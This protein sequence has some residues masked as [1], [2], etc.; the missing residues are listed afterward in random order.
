MVRA[1]F[2][3]SDTIAC[4]LLRGDAV[5]LHTNMDPKQR[6]I[7][8]VKSGVM[9]SDFYSADVMV[10]QRQHSGQVFAECQRANK[11]GITTVYDIDDDFLN[12]PREFIKPY[13][14]YS[15]PGT[16]ASIL[17]FLGEVDEVWV[18]TPE[19]QAAVDKYTGGATPSRIVQNY[20][21]PA[22]WNLA[23][24]LHETNDSDLVTVGWMASGSH[25][26][27][28][29]LV[30][31]ALLQLLAEHPNVRL[32]FIG[33]VGFSEIPGLEAFK[34][35]VRVDPW[36]DLAQLPFAMSGWDIGLC[37]LQDNKFN[38]CKS[39]IKYMQYGS[40]GCVPV[41]SPLRLYREVAKDKGVYAEGNWYE[42]LKKLVVEKDYRRD[43]ALAIRADVL[44]NWNMK[45]G[46]EE[47]ISAY[48][49]VRKK[50]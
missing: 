40:F 15:N 13:Q 17:A 28:A 36:V 47:W 6:V 41:M 26:I 12:T 42:V 2:Y 23:Y 25:S 31:P 34:D 18:T 14:F 29:P 35:R 24:A 9:S 21:D 7:I 44:E 30:G 10:F 19:L 39:A 50:A 1:K 22:P 32:H 33:W 37:P 3:L 38:R 11:M 20:V 16:R 5:A 49:N 46:V 27:D 8:D 43:T 48:E 45:T 4:G